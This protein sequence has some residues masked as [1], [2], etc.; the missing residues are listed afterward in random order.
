M[1]NVCRYSVRRSRVAAVRVN[2]ISGA[3]EGLATGIAWRKG[4]FTVSV[5]EQAPAALVS[6]GSAA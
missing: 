5:C 1:H 3:S 4:R 6:S 2:V